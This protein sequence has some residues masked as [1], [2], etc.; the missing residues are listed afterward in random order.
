[1][2]PSKVCAK[3]EKPVVLVDFPVR[4]ASPDGYDRWCKVC[5]REYD[6]ERYKISRDKM[7]GER[8]VYAK[9]EH[10]KEVRNDWARKRK[11]RLRLDAVQK[12]GGKCSNSECRWVNDDGTLG[13]TDPEILQIDH[14]H[15]GGHQERKRVGSPSTYYKLIIADETGKYQLLCANCNWKKR[16]ENGELFRL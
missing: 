8:L 13:C 11:R 12:L 10:G 1:M 15:G 9:S 14:K 16:Y 5:H 2:E 6:K 3:C 7:L 4:D